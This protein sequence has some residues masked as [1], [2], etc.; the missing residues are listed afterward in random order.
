MT[1]LQLIGR[2]CMLVVTSYSFFSYRLG[3]AAVKFMSYASL[4]L[5]ALSSIMRIPHISFPGLRTAKP[6]T[7]VLQIRLPPLSAA[8]HLCQHKTLVHCKYLYI[9]HT[10]IF[11]SCSDISNLDSQMRAWIEANIK[12]KLPQEVII[13]HDRISFLEEGCQLLPHRHSKPAYLRLAG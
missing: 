5:E 3:I 6:W 11:C 12:L 4:Q 7:T 13:Y 9:V 8:S 1:P 10:D 2:I